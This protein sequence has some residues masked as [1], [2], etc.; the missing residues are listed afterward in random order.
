MTPP[1]ERT[2]SI[3]IGASSFA[4][5]NAAMKILRRL[6]FGAQM[7]LGGLFVEELTATAL[8]GLPNQRVVS[9]SGMLVVAPSPPQFR[10]V[11]EAEMK[12]FRNTLASIAETTGT[13]WSFERSIGD[14][15][16]QSMQ[17]AAT[18]DVIIFGHQALHPVRGKIVLLHGPDAD[19]DDAASLAGHLAKAVFADIENMYVGAARSG[20]QGERHHYETIG[21]AIQALARMNVQA[22]VLDISRGPVRTP[23]QLRQLLEAARCPV[24]AL[25]AAVPGTEL[26]HSTQIPPAPD[27]GR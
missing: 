6:R 12:A 16:Q 27:S 21:S 7:R 20:S 18:W 17:A 22:V 8:C 13:R 11:I 9:T 10:T 5:A 3:L 24:I 15:V 26:E 2:M 1:S 23:E 19:S 25:G 14:L 4:D